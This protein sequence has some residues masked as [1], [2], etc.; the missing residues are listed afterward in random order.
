[1]KRVQ[2]VVNLALFVLLA[3]QWNDARKMR[4]EIG[5]FTERLR[6]IS[7]WQSDHSGVAMP[8]TDA[9]IPAP[10]PAAT[11]RAVSASSLVAQLETDVGR[12][13]LKKAV[14]D[15]MR[16]SQ[17]EQRQADALRQQRIADT[18]REA[19]ARELGLSDGELVRL[20]DLGRPIQDVRD[21]ESRGELP[22][23]KVRDELERISRETED[24]LHGVLG[25]ERYRKLV[26]LRREHPEYGRYLL[27]LQ[28]PYLPP[29]VNASPPPP[30]R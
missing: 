20:E 1:M 21:R 4:S 13:E 2:V 3:A 30:A 16:A 24:E 7:D 14:A 29:S 10:V 22:P 8:P 23:L 9:R 12:S 28:P 18:G 27:A 5:R 19:A 11:L 6:E 15:Q 25:D 26:E 17:E